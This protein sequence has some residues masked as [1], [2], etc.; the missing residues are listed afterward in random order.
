M[1]DKPLFEKMNNFFEDN[2]DLGPKAPSQCISLEDAKALL[3]TI[4]EATSHFPSSIGRGNLKAKKANVFNALFELSAYIDRT[5]NESEELKS[6]LFNKQGTSGT[7]NSDTPITT[8]IEQVN[9]TQSTVTL[10]NLPKTE[11]PKPGGQKPTWSEIL[12]KTNLLETNTVRELIK[13]NPTVNIL[14]T[15]QL[16]N[17]CKISVANKDE[18]E[19]LRRDLETKDFSVRII[20][21]FMPVLRL[22]RVPI[23]YSDDF[24]RGHFEDPKILRSFKRGPQARD[25]LIAINPKKFNEIIANNGLAQLDKWTTI[26]CFESTDAPI[27]KKCG[28]LGHGIQRC[29][30]TSIRC[31]HCAESGHS[32]AECTSTNNPPKCINCIDKNCHSIDH[33]VTDRKCPTM[34]KFMAQRRRNTDYGF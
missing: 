27:C 22:T 20:N 6:L 32:K 11:Q 10:K 4:A 29:K 28:L 34:A 31:T 19:R 1:E 18:A 13:I 7:N 26:K 2:P 24:L 9:S 8:T 12:V 3:M 30:A 5:S 15:R 16:E 25:I 23:A 21:K 33:S 14:R 17:G